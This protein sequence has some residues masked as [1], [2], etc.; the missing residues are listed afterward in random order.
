MPLK[1]WDQAFL[2]VV[3]LINRLPSKVIQNMTPIERLLGHQADYTSLRVLGCACWPN[4]WPYNSHKL[5][6]CSFSNLHKGYKCLDISIGRIYI[7]RD[8]V[9]AVFLFAQLHE[10]AG[11]RLRS[12][13]SLLPPFWLNPPS[14]GDAHLHD[15]VHD[16]HTHASNSLSSS[17]DAS[18]TNSS[19]IL[20]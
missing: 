19:E 12:E 2:S 16:D 4:L 13:I 9:F 7:S 18:P 14:S 15:H 11:A 5:Q 1:Y 8:V 6:F 17:Q 10:N 3:Y 20:N